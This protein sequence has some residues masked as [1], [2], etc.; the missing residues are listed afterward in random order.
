MRPFERE[1]YLAETQK[2]VSQVRSFVSFF[3]TRLNIRCIDHDRTKLIEPEVSVFAEL[4]PKLKSSSYG[5]DEYKEFLKQLGP[6]LEHH[7]A[8]NRHHPEFFENG[9]RDMN[10]IDIIEMFCD[11]VA[12]AKRHDSG[13]IMKSIDLN[14]E[15]FGMSDDIVDI[16]KNTAKL[17]ENK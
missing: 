16:F 2:H 7:Y 13:D 4:T 5:S 14:K 6:A 3:T 8:H 11:W 12:A 10:L 15:R 9:Y 17:F 1:N